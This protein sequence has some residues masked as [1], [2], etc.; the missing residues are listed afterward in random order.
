M[1]LNEEAGAINP[2]QREYLSYVKESSDR[3]YRLLRELLDISKI[4]SGQARM[5]CDLT[6]LNLLLKEEM[7]LFKN[8]AQEK[9]ITVNVEVAPD[10]KPLYC[11]TDKMREVLDNLL[12]NAFKFTLPPGKVRIHAR[13]QDSGIEISVEDTGIGIRKEDQARIFEPFQ[14]IE[15]SG[16]PRGEES[17]GLGLALVKKIVEAHGGQI[18]VQSEEGKG[19]AFTVHLPFEM[20]VKNYAELIGK[21]Q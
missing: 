6:D 10:L 14:H 9:G 1:V 17:T 19:S 3:L 11:D 2:E 12:S 21:V 15:K 5:Q 18:A 4:E 8:M 13:N 20:K 7:A 16:I